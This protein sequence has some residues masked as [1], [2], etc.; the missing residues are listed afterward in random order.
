[1]RWRLDEWAGQWAADGRPVT[2]DWIA[3]A[4][5]ALIPGLEA[6]GVIGTMPNIPA[7]RINAQL[8]LLGPSHTVSAEELSGLHALACA[9]D[10][11][12]RGEIDA[13]LVGAVDLS[14]ETVHQAAAAHLF[15]LQR[16][17]PGDAAVVLLLKRAVD[18]Q[19]DGDQ[20]LA[21]IDTAPSQ[22]K[23][24]ATP[25]E[26]SV[27]LGVGQLAVNGAFGH[28]HAAAGL[29]HVAVGTLCLHDRVRLA[30]GAG[31]MLRPAEPW[32]AAG[33]RSVHVQVDALGGQSQT[34]V[35]RTADAV[36]PWK[37][38]ASDFKQGVLQVFSGADAAA[39]LDAVQRNEESTAG[40]ARL[41]IV[42]Q[43]EATGEGQRRL[44]GEALA[45]IVAGPPPA[46]LAARP[47]PLAKGIYW[48]A[49]PMA[50]ELGFVF[51]PA[52][53]AYQGM[54]RELLFALPDLGDRV[55]GKFPCLAHTQAW[56]AVEPQ[57]AASDPFQVLQGC[58]LLSQLHATLL[59]E[60]LG[61][62]P[63]AVLGVSSG[64]TNSMFATGAWTDMDAMFAEIDAAG[65]YTREIAGDY[66]AA[67]RAW[68]DR[69]A[70]PIEWAGWRVLAPVAEVEA[71]LQGEEFASLTM[72]NAPADCLVA[73]QA[74]ACRRVVEK[75]G[76]HRCVENANEI[77]AHHPAVKSWEQEWRTIHHRETHPVAGVRFYSNARGG[78]Y[79][80][81]RERVAD[82]LTDQ[83]TGGVDFRRVVNA[84]WQDGVR[85]FVE[86]GPRNV[87]SGWIRSILGERDHLVVALDRQQNGVEQLL[88]AV[89]QLVAAG[90]AVDYQ[91]LAA[92]LAVPVQAPEPAAA[93]RRMLSLPAHYPPVSL[94]A[95]A[96]HRSA[97]IPVSAPAPAPVDALRKPNA[98]PVD[99]QRMEPPPL[100]PP[101]LAAPAQ[102][103][104]R[105]APQ[106]AAVPV[107]PPSSTVAPPPVLS[108]PAPQPPA[109]V[110]PPIAV[111]ALVPPPQPPA[112]NP[113]VEQLTVFH[114]GVSAAHQHFLAQQER[115]MAR[116]VALYGAAGALPASQTLPAPQA[117]SAPVITPPVASVEAPPVASPAPVVQ[118][119]PVAK[120]APIP[121]PAP[122]APVLPQP[123]AA[124]KAVAP[125]AAPGL[126]LGGRQ[127]AAPLAAA[128]RPVRQ[129]RASYPGPALDRG[130][131]EHLA[132]GKISEILG[133]VFA[134]QDHFVRQVRMPMPPLLLADRVLGIDA[135]A[136]AVGQ[137]G[138]IWTE[139][140]VRPD[141]W[142]LHNGRVPVGVLIEAGQ[143]DLLLV[144]YLGAD[145]VNKSERVYRLLGCEVTFHAE[146]PR[147]GD[148][149]HYEIHL[150]SYAQQGPV[151]LFFFHYDCFSGDRLIFS[152]RQGQAGFFTDDELANSNGVIWDARTAEI[153][154]S[155]RLA[156]PAIRCERS[157]F[158]AEQ[159]VAFAE[160]RVVECFGE[161][162]RAAETHVR[163][164]TIARGRM[165]FFDHV[166]SFDPAGGPWGRGYLR[167]DDHLTPEKW[168]FA[169]HFKNDP[170]M[171]GTMMYE[172]CLQT[173]AFYMAALGFTVD[174]DGWRFE[175]VLEE[176]YKLVCRG[177][178]IPSNKHVIYELFVEEVIHGA[179]PTL[180]A[181]LLVTVDGL[182][183][184]HCRRMGLR[185]APGFPLESRQSLFDGAEMLDPAPERNV[186]T[187]DHVYGPRSIAA[188]AWGKPS[189]AF[190]ELFA[191]FDGPE[192]CPRL[193]GPPYLY[194]TRITAIDA[195]KGVPVSGGTVEAEYQ[196]PPDG[197][198]F[199]ENGNRTMPYAVLLEAALQ[200]C[201]WFASY[202]GSVLH[203]SEELYFRNL[204]GTATQHREV[205]PEDGV[206]RTQV[207]NTSVSRLGAMTITGFEVEC[208]IGE[209]LVFEMTTTFGFFPKAALAS[210][211]GLP[212]SDAL[213]ARLAEPCEFRRELRP[214]PPRYFNTLPALPGPMLLLLDR[215]T[216][217]WPHGGAQ[218]LSRVRAEIDVNP[219]DWF[220]KCHFMGDSVQPGSLGLE[221]M[222]QALQ[223][224]MIESGL[225]AGLARP[226]FEPIQ[227]GE[228][229][230]WKYRGQVLPTATRVTVDLEIV[231]RG[232]AHAVANASLWV[233]GLRIY[234]AS[235]LGMRI[236]DDEPAHLHTGG[237]ALLDPAQ[238][239][240][241]Q[242]H[243]PTWTVPAL[244]MMSMVDRLAAG[245]LLR[246]P[247]RKVT[248]LRA[249]RVH[250]WLSFAAGAQ[251]IKLLGRPMGSDTVA[252]QLLVWEEAYCRFSLVASGD[253][254]MTDDWQLAEQPWPALVSPPD[255]PDPYAAG[256]LFHGPA[257]QL[258]TD[259]KID[260]GGA[261]YWLDLEAGDVPVGALNQGLL[262]AAT[263]G[264]PHDALWRWS[265]EIPADVAAYPVA[266]TGAHF[267]GPAPVAGRVR[268]A[269][270]FAGFQ[271]GDTRFPM[272]DVQIMAGD[273]VW[274]QFRLVETL[275]P[276]GPLG[277]AA[278]LARRAFLVDR[279]Y[280]PGMALSGHENGVTTLSLATVKASDWL[281]GTVASIYAPEYGGVALGAEPLA[282]VVAVKEHVARQWQ[283][284]PAQLVVALADERAGHDTPDVKRMT[285][286]VTSPMLPLNRVGV[287]ARLHGETWQI[288]N[289]DNAPSPSLDLSAV[290]DFWRTRAHAGSTVVEDLTLALMQRFVRRVEITDP[291]GFASVQ[292]RGVLYLA[293]HQLDLESA[294][295]VSLIAALQGTVTT[296]IARQELG[297]SWIGPYFDICFQHPQI[298]DPHMLLLIDRASP[299]AVF[300]SLEGALERTRSQQNSLLVH[301]EGAH[302][303]QA[304]R[305]VEVIST[306]LIDL[307]V[308]KDVPIVPLRFFGGLPVAPVAEPL[309]FPVDYGR[310]DFLVG[311]PLLPE[312]LAP[313]SSAE[314][315][316]RVLAALNGFDERWQH[317]TPNPGD[318]AFAAEVAQWRQTKGVSEVQA[319][320]YRTLCEAAAPSA[321]TQWLLDKVQGKRHKGFVPAAEVKQWLA[322]VASQL[323]GVK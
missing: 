11:L 249:V 197:W 50:G 144:S 192:R 294:L 71:A 286:V 142:Y 76:R 21:I 194:M 107:A 159:V 160:G 229:M 30:A 117:M 39:L 275:F 168:F 15:D 113:M 268:C 136:G 199:S 129:Y 145:F 213:R 176:S 287:Q 8:N 132:S 109:P 130:Q 178:V 177:Q 48:A 169:G 183:A 105:R 264:I 289:L 78:A 238:E 16:Q 267:Y 202:K 92:A 190:G 111:A 77:I 296:A 62:K 166:V 29:L 317:E 131:L 80:P 125:A 156:P 231:E 24:N 94:P 306:A 12:R 149:L 106:P 13:A 165:L 182:A 204:D 25:G 281:A 241:L 206:L 184:F 97:A 254:I 211:A 270:R 185:L 263:H 118:A 319:V 87:C 227:L 4:K 60:W 262:D 315:R 101:V 171:P 234:E 115:A 104:V 43:G 44:A 188:C 67:R 66:Q 83:A 323:L 18:A 292:G 65:M 52:A 81:D 9:A 279:R 14:V 42:V 201:G 6:A 243:C 57:P 273:A 64:E 162:F 36:Q 303:L 40:P 75:I 157:S 230:V 174:R 108:P 285:A 290:Q 139:T 35:L 150:D 27:G 305:P 158:S 151:R 220:F 88:D 253:V 271:G 26:I 135:E 73:G 232:D 257:Y 89:A 295:F 141:A 98:M 22:V 321:E 299:E 205:F 86:Q 320:L 207:R 3:A 278:P 209:E 298:V 175:P 219:Q 179:T 239:P 58:A 235:R 163:T 55:I 225:G 311:A 38:K 114:A 180:Y 224:F 221:A 259:L 53:A 218:G 217:Y 123:V 2:P 59:Q 244:A 313:L 301:V 272:V 266:M 282:L 314:R 167:A 186:R 170:C 196:I 161:A 187:P 74:A 277:Q 102:E 173:M 250:R 255:E 120:P 152:V 69:D 203:S 99:Y 236:V 143:A 322:V 193:P 283:L 200:P 17:T 133:P 33:P 63:D 198:Y 248:G 100:L 247:G 309:A 291:A 280:V 148:T 37:G 288:G 84:A 274:A 112:H 146:L 172:G 147:V 310:Q 246:A 61:V 140:D 103:Q 212:V 252:M 312:L 45:R 308:A 245:A 19:R 242:D 276:K 31:G 122:A 70:G 195:A 226:R 297:E 93:P 34:L 5:A 46:P 191:R 32:L 153:V 216:G 228:P 1:M 316:V 237:D 47:M 318:A 90:V 222:I 128:V 137:K 284:H 82:A 223:F 91:R 233:D 72:I 260:D 215:I 51:T 54:G 304:R 49:A 95:L 110:A 208:F 240:W 210:Q 116:L 189:D 124:A 300:R 302:A 23:G 41:V 258:L 10:A 256:V 261:S 56:L 79:V 121:P 138:V 28:A 7:N 155:P 265:G 164:P 126:Q 85:I 96:P 154:G 251:R 214:R 134:Q 20:I 293:N 119:T 68:Q 307:A 269:A 181:D 127:P